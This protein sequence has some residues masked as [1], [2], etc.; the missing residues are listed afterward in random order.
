MQN[1]DKVGVLF[2][3]DQIELFIP[4]KK[5]KSHILRIIRELIAFEPEEKEILEDLIVAAHND[6]KLKL[7]KKTTPQNRKANKEF[8]LFNFIFLFYTRDLCSKCNGY[9]LSPANNF[10]VHCYSFF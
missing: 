3:T 10:L 5:G 8:E 1:N 6:A 9:W 2:F 4:P 7:K